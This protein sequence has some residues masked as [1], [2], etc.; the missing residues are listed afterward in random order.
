MVNLTKYELKLIAGNRGIKNYQNMSRKKLLRALNKSDH[1]FE[2]I[3]LNRLERI[4]KMENLS[5]NE[6]KQIKRM[7]NLLQ[8]ELGQIAEMRRIKNY[9]NMSIEELLIAL[10]KSEQSH[11]ELYKSKSKIND[12]RN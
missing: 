10:L 5:Q 9:K 3:S 4:A 7:K 2:N 12:K 1:N 8:N 6:L 11:A